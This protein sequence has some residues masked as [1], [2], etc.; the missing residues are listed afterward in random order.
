[1]SVP[2]SSTTCVRLRGG[3]IVDNDLGVICSLGIS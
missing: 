3:W 2:G 1:M